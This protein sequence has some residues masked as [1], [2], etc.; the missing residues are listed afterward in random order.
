MNPPES[1]PPIDVNPKTGRTYEVLLCVFGLLSL[2]AHFAS[3]LAFILI[4]AAFYFWLCR[5]EKKWYG[6]VGLVSAS[7]SLG[8]SVFY[9][10]MAL[11]GHFL[12]AVH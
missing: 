6:T 12:N 10:G 4:A 3:L 11:F 2:A 5:I 1:P 8:L 9:L 7:V